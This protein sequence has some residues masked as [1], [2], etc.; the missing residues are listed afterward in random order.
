MDKFLNRIGLYFLFTKNKKNTIQDIQSLLRQT[1]IT[2]D[3]EKKTKG[4][5]EDTNEEDIL[6]FNLTPLS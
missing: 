3:V 5:K 1:F 2:N 4:G 6:K